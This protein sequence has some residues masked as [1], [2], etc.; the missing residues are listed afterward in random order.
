MK[1]P[2]TS[3]PRPHSPSSEGRRSPIRGLEH[4]GLTVP[5]LDDAVRFFCDVLDCEPLYVH[6]P[7]A[8]DR[9]GPENFYVKYVGL[10]PRTVGRIAMLRCGNGSNLELFEFDAP[11]QS[12]QMPPFS[13]YGGAHLSF[14]VDDMEA[15]VAHLEKKGVKMTG[16]VAD[17]D[18]GPEAG[19]D[20][21]SA[22]FYTPWGQMLELISYPRGRAYEAGT[23]ERLWVPNQPATWRNP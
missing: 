19:E 8:D 14:Y 16:G 6:G 2:H 11:G 17:I 15:A 10:D 7:Y 13:D 22:H 20:S 4:I 5:D 23:T 18:E 1:A 12:K 9:E 21:T 3:T